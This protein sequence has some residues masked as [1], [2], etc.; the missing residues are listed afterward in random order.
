MNLMSCENQY[1]V[2]SLA[3]LVILR[4]Y[5]HIGVTCMILLYMLLCLID[6]NLE[7]LIILRYVLA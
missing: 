5:C 2:S 7:R 1:T 3:R 4:L 6:D